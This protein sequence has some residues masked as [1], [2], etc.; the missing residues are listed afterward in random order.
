[1]K[2]SSLYIAPFACALCIAPLSAFAQLNPTLTGIVVA[3]V[4][5]NNVYKSEGVKANT[6]YSRI[7]PYLNLAF[8][9]HL[10]LEA[11]LVHEPVNQLQLATLRHL[12][13]R[14]HLQKS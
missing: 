1:M 5:H 2:R 3:E 4:Q 11:S 6:T 12:P 13:M 14:A 8:T 7:E 10:N 9:E